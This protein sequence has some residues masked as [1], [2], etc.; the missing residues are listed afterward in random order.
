MPVL[1]RDGLPLFEAGPGELD[2]EKLSVQ[3]VGDRSSLRFRVKR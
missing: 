2:L 1:L 3:E